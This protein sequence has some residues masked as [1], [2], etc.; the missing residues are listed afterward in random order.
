MY[1]CPEKPVTAK[2]ETCTFSSKVSVPVRIA[3]TDSCF[4]ATALIDSVVNLIDHHLVQQFKIP[5]IPCTPPL[6]FTDINDQPIGE[7]L[8]LHQTISIDL[9]IGLFH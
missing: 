9:Q 6:K 1:E 2:V 4:H 5:V 3:L 8:I 7:G